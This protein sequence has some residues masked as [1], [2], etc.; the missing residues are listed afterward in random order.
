M[1]RPHRLVRDFSVLVDNINHVRHRP[2]GTMHGTTEIVHKQFG[3]NPIL[4]PTILRELELLLPALVRAIIFAW[5]GFTNVYCQKLKP[6]VAIAYLELV[7]G[8]DLAHERR[9]SNA[10]E[11]EEDMLFSP[12][13]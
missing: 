13:G 6:F 8:R 9:S 12:K 1:I 2:V 10:A 7:E 5:V 11:L 4:F 3:L